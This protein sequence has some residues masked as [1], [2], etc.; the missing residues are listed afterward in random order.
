M[1]NTFL[2]TTGTAVLVILMLAIFAQIQVSAQ[3]KVDEQQIE[4]QTEG[5]FFPPS[6]RTLEGSWNVQATFVNCQ[7]GAA[8]RSF[9]AMSTFMRGGTMQ[10]FGI[11]SGFLRGP[12]HGVWSQ[13]R[14]QQNYNYVFQFFRFNADN[15]YAGKVVARADI[16]LNTSASAFTATSTIEFLSP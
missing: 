5:I 14:G 7:T 1:K 4:N 12:G 15:T 3:D 11:A 2:K 16:R 8:I 10:E 13:G 9:P 6:E